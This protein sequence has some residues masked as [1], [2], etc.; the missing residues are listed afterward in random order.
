MD[1]ITLV[2]KKAFLLDKIVASLAVQDK[3]GVYEE[4]A[5]LSIEAGYTE[6]EAISLAMSVYDTYIEVYSRPEVR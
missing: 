1:E 4:I 2:N 6:K 3:T 5:A